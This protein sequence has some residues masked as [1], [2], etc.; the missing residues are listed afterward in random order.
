MVINLWKP[1]EFTGFHLSFLQIDGKREHCVSNLKHVFLIKMCLDENTRPR[2]YT[3]HQ[4]KNKCEFSHVY[5]QRDVGERCDEKKRKNGTTSLSSLL[6]FKSMPLRNPKRTSF[7]WNVLRN[8][9]KR[10]RNVSRAPTITSRLLII[11]LNPLLFSLFFIR[12]NCTEQFREDTNNDNNNYNN[13]DDNK[14]NKR[15]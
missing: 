5:F 11:L 12:E 3:I 15:T 9:Y 8:S 2:V 13:N 4:T 6:C 7:K 14:V 10:E 1:L